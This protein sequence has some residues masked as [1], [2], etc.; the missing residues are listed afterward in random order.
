MAAASMSDSDYELLRSPGSGAFDVGLV[1]PTWN[2]PETLKRMLR[3]LSASDLE[4]VAVLLVDDASDSAE[5]RQL[6]ATADARFG[7]ARR[8]CRDGPNIHQS[9][10]YGW[11]LLLRECRCRYLVGLDSDTLVKPDWIKRLRAL[12][13]KLGP[14]YS[15]L[16]LT[17]F[18]TP[19]HALLDRYGDYG[20]KKSVGGVNLFFGAELYAGLIRPSLQAIFWDWYLM[21]ACQEQKVT[22]ACTLPSVVQHIGS[23][24]MWSRGALFHDWAPDYKFPKPVARILEPLLFQMRRLYDFVRHMF[25]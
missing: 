6:L 17:G 2:R 16:L 7:L 22:L 8:R 25:S 5:T 23:S 15:R 14:R 12:H 18:H 11:D 1:I 21:E 9:L 19:G 10:K 13:D 4:G 3:S 20:V 24:G